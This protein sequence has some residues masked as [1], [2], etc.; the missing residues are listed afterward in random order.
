MLGVAVGVGWFVLGRHRQWLWLG[1]PYALH[2]LMDIPTH[3]RYRTQPFY[4]LSDWQISGLSWADP[5]IFWPHLGVL[6]VACVWAWR[7]RQA[8]SSK[9]FVAV[10]ILLCIMALGVHAQQQFS[11]F[12]SIVVD[13][14]GAPVAALQPT[15][16]RVLENGV[17][18]RV[19][20]VEPV[21]WPT[22]VQLLMDNGV[23]LGATNANQLTTGVRGLLDALPPGV[24]VTIVTT[25]PQPRIIARA[26]TDRQ[27][28]LKGLGL[29][30]P[31]SGVGRFLESLMDATQRIE[32]DKGDYFP[33]IVLAGTT[34]GD[35]LV[36]DSD[37][38]RLMKRLEQ[39]P[40][41][42]HVVLLSGQVQSTLGGPNQ[43]EIGLAV[44]KYTNG[45]FENINS[46]TRLATLLPE[47]GALVARDHEV[48]SRQFRIIVDRPAG[49]SGGLGTV[50]L[51]ANP[52]LTVKSVSLDG[53][54]SWR[55]RSNLHLAS[56][57]EASRK[58]G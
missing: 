21:N 18:A 42:V 5:R 44:T 45:R 6:A 51:S 49:A 1:L 13:A 30:A 17:E 39:R 38:E 32:R 48:Q 3:E 57:V 56:G 26:T 55:S 46:A 14:T 54:I 41:T 43:T 52:E 7:R 36:L 9:L 31:D 27:A 2:I 35:R 8:A 15:D 47:I 20:K 12:A 10:G 53:R 40:T 4:P 22:K 11:L 29:F 37:F 58:V 50:S 33:V 24:E 23:G 19:V 25:A 16:V 28:M 34:A